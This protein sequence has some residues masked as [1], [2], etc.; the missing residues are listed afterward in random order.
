LRYH[1]III[2]TDADVDGSHIRTLLLTFFF[3][4]MPELIEQGYIYIAQPPLYKVKKGKQ[5]QYIKDDDSLNY[6]LTQVAIDGAELI[7]EE[8]A[9]PIAGAQLEKLILQYQTVMK[10]ISKLAR[11]YPSA[12]LENLL[13]LSTVTRDTLRDQEATQAWTDQLDALL[14]QYNTSTRV[15]S[16]EITR[17][18]ESGLYTPCIT[19]VQHGLSQTYRMSPEF[20]DSEDY[21]KIN[22]LGKVMFDLFTGGALI[23]R[24]TKELQTERMAEMMT[25]LMNEAQRGYN[26]QRYKG[27]GEMNPD[28]LWETTMDPAQRRM[29]QVSVKD[30]IAADQIFT[31]LMG[32]DV[33][34]RREFI[35]QNALLVE[36]LDY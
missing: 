34:P 9:P 27:L 8:G 20:F 26:I 28:Q 22:A 16:A 13:Y 31:T 36:N 17:N 15:Y 4:Q 21:R 30:A 5:E 14:Q 3:R 7:P 11:V 25:W 19:S 23:R 6:Y 35:Q 10:A 1:K 12:V 2:M 29:L 18:E 32:D 24:N 33:E